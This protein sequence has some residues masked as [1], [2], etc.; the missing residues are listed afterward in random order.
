MTQP[1][2]MPRQALHD[3]LPEAVLL[4]QAQAGSATAF[5]ILMRRHNQLL[6]RCARSMVK[7]DAEAEDVVQEAYLRA[8]RALASF[9]ADSRLATWLV[10]IVRNEA[11]GRLR[12]HKADIIPLG[13]ALSPLAAKEDDSMVDEIGLSPEQALFRQQMR[14][15]LEARIDHL[16]EVFRSVFVLRAVEEMSVE[17]VAQLLEIPEATVRSRFFRARSLL[18]EG[19]AQDVDLAMHEV[20]AFDGERCNR[21]VAAVLAR[22]EAEGLSRAERP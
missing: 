16:P 12:G 18:R 13:A 8:W 15:L 9:R 5:E 2:L 20:F 21:I 6:F 1:T 3:Q 7:Q 17:D 10:R 11:L 14:G 19:M 22:A 4:Q